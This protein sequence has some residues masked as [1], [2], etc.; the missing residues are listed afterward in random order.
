MDI[1]LPIANL[2]VS[3]PSTAE[4]GLWLRR[5]RR[6]DETAFALIY[7]AH[8]A[9]VYSLAWR[10]TADRLM[11]EDI[12]QETLMRL[13]R[14]MGGA[15][16]DRPL[17]PWLNTVASRLAID[18][19]RCTAREVS[20]FSDDALQAASVES[21]VYAEASGLLR[22]LSPVARTLVWLNQVEGWTHQELG[23]R[24]GRSESWSKSIV[25]RALARLRES[26]DSLNIDTRH[27]P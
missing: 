20:E 8:A 15:D 7:Q 23:K 17:R 6:G 24:F 1:R 16:P 9:A 2:A 3:A 18:H 22:H 5:A 26:V 14:R 19:L 11:A 21:E 13:M 12:T 4:E 25:S 10:L 27:D